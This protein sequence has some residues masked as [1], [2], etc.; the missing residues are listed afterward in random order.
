MSEDLRN[1]VRELEQKVGKLEEQQVKDFS[2]Q[3]GM[4]LSFIRPLIAVV[5]A[6]LQTGAISA[7]NALANIPISIDGS[8]ADK[9]EE[10]SDRRTIRSW[11]GM[12]KEGSYDAVEAKSE[13]F[14]LLPGWLAEH[15]GEDPMLFYAYLIENHPQV[16]Q[17]PYS[18]D[19]WQVVHAWMNECRRKLAG[20]D[21]D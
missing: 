11:A 4:S 18:S 21:D 14:K 10:K 17:F 7:D 5:R 12:P 8:A 15:E 9:S 19:R 2:K 3:L 16:L 6:G 20:D 1:R 13:V